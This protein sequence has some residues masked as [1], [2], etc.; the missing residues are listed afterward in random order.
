MFNTSIVVMEDQ[1]EILKV[2]VDT[3]SKI[4]NSVITS[5]NNPLEGLNYTIRNK[6]DIIVTDNLMPYVDGLYVAKKI[7]EVYNPKIILASVI[8]ADIVKSHK[9]SNFDKYLKKPFDPIELLK[10][11]IDMTDDINN[12]KT[13]ILYKV[14]SG[15]LAGINCVG[16][17]RLFINNVVK[18]LMYDTD[19]PPEDSIYTI[20]SNQLEKDKSTIRR[21]INKVV[22]KTYE[23]SLFE[24]ILGFKQRPKNREFVDALLEKINEQAKNERW[25]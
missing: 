8:T 9:L 22:E 12:R 14:T 20:L 21:N 13:I 17:D 4:K 5:F 24:R 1:P 3:L 19:K 10:I 6:P 15:V 11:V 18:T 25:D 7:R 23:P 2:Y 16:K